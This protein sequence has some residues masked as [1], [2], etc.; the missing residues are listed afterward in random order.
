MS[1]KRTLNE[2]RQTKEFGYRQPKAKKKIKMSV[3]PGK[4][5]NKPYPILEEA[6]Q[7]FFMD[8]NKTLEQSFLR[9]I[10]VGMIVGTMLGIIIHSIYM[11][12]V[13]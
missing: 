13:L 12:Y 5:F 11:A 8:I 4:E 10:F 9:G 3:P 2:Y 1:K 7:E 6:D